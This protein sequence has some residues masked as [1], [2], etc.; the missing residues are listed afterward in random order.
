[1]SGSGIYYLL[2]ALFMFGAVSSGINTLGIAP[3]KIP[4]RDMSMGVATVTD[5]SN[6]ATSSPSFDMG[7]A[8]V[9]FLKILGGG[10]TA[11]FASPVIFYDW[12]ILAGANSG[13]AMVVGGIFGV[14]LTLFVLVNLYDLATGRN[15]T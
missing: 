5:Y 8:I 12:M 3:V 4:A 13:I 1:M 15:T 2:L 14:P 11:I 7:S 6:A 10:V 9:S